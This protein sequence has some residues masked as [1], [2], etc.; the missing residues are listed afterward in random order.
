[1]FIIPSPEQVVKVLLIVTVRLIVAMFKITG[2][3]FLATWQAAWYT[4]HGQKHMVGDSI[5]RFDE[6]IVN[7]LADIVTFKYVTPN[8]AEGNKQVALGVGTGAH[9]CPC[10]SRGRCRRSVPLFA[11]MP[12]FP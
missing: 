1:M 7:A 3:V 6:A 12:E 4:A 8:R 2:Y 10:S 5:G 9:G 11:R